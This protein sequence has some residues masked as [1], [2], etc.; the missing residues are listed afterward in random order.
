MEFAIENN[1]VVSKD[2]EELKWGERGRMLKEI[3]LCIKPWIV[4]YIF[5]PSN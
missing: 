2:D 1:K 5:F 4:E 3:S